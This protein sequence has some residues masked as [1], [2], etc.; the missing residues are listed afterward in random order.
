MVGPR[1]RLSTYL[2]PR[3]LTNLVPGGAEYRAMN[4]R[5]SLLSTPEYLFWIPR[6]AFYPC[7][8]AAH[9]WRHCRLCWGAPSCV[10]HDMVPRYPQSNS[11]G[12]LAMPDSSQR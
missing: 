6:T 1:A 7:E 10:V 11:D 4:I 3:R 8:P 2:R 9:A 12:P 5:C